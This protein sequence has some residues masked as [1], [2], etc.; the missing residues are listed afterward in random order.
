MATKVERQA[1][2]EAEALIEFKAATKELHAAELKAQELVAK[3]KER[4]AKAL[5][6]LHK[7]AI[8][9]K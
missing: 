3:A 1:E 7:L 2:M 6:A 4:Y 9:E 5:Q 8:E